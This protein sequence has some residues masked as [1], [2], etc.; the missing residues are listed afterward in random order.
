[1]NFRSAAISSRV[2]S[3]P[4]AETSSAS[5]SSE[6]GSWLARVSCR[7]QQPDHLVGQFAIVGDGVE[8]LERSTKRLAPR[9]DFRLVFRHVFRVTRVG[10]AEPPDHRRQPEPQS[11]QRDENDAEAD[12]QNEV[13]VWEALAIRKRERQ[14]QRRGQRYRAAHAGERDHEYRAPR[15]RRIARAQALAPDSRQVYRGIDPGETRHDDDHGPAR[16]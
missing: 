12:E 16:S 7:A 8:R 5:G 14:R 1:M 15:W 13:A 3:I 2:R 4:A 9:R 11:D 6:S 10:D